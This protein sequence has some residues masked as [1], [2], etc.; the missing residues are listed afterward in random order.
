MYDLAI[1][2]T[3]WIQMD[4]KGFAPKYPIENLV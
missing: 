4:R 3:N 1:P 2:S